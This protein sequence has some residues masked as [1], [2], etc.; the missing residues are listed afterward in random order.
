MNYESLRPGSSKRPTQS[1]SNTLEQFM[2]EAKSKG[3]TG[4]HDTAIWMMD[5]SETWRS[6]GYDETIKQIKE[7]DEDGKNED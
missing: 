1:K 4:L 6:K 2:A 7:F 3:V 5:V